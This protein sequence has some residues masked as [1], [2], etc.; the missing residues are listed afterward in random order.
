VSSGLPKLAARESENVSAD[1]DAAETLAACSTACVGGASQEALLADVLLPVLVNP[2]HLLN[3]DTLRASCEGDRVVGIHNIHTVKEDE[4]F[5][6][7]CR[8]VD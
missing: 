7:N 8:V 1:A 5:E 4:G 6:A 2:D 3:D